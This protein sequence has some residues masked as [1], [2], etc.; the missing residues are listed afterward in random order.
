MCIFAHQD[1]GQAPVAQSALAQMSKVVCELSNGGEVAAFAIL[2]SGTPSSVG[3]KV[4]VADEVQFFLRSAIEEVLA[5]FLR[6]KFLAAK[7]ESKGET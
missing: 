3:F 5:E 4:A 1:L 7:V 2:E 6:H